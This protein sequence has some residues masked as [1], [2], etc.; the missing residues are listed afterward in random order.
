MADQPSALQS[1]RH[2]PRLAILG[3]LIVVAL[4]AGAIIV[5]L[6][7]RS[8][9]PGPVALAASPSPQPSIAT[10]SASPSPSPSPTPTATPAPTPSPTPPIEALTGTDGRLTMLVMGSDYRRG[11]PGNRTDTMMVISVDPASGKVAIASI[12]RDTVNFPLPDGS[13]FH[14]KVNGL[15]QS[16][17]ARMGD[18]AAGAAM[19]RT[20]GRA[21]RVEIDKFV[22]I[23]FDG[24]KRLV[25]AVGGV[26]VVLARAVVDPAYWL[27]PTRH[28]VRFPAGKNHL[29][30]E[31]ALIFARTRK[32]DNDFERA[33][34][35]QQLMAAAVE[36]VRKGGL[37]VLPKLLKIAAVYV[38][39]D[40]PFTEAARIFGIVESAR[41]GKAAGAVFGPNKW[42]TS[43][44]GTSFALKIGEIRKWTARFMAPI[45]K[46]SSSP[47]P[48]PSGAPSSAP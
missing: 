9:S 37:A 5:A 18:A 13:A 31:R 48:S 26:D 1:I 45:P 47:A 25:D 19:K 41:T 40:I 42:A 32:G 43:T 17:V 29:T 44:G 7:A 16:Y 20:V 33:R 24:V 34:R 36:A 6:A 23:G 21:L 11:H 15:F 3:A 27:S 30:G 12:P 39:T 2:H 35:Q 22:V 38:Q 4:V 10:P 28:G 14:P 8:E 46:A